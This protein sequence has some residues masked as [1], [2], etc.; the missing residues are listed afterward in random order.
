MDFAVKKFGRQHFI[1]DVPLWEGHPRHT[2]NAR[3]NGSTAIVDETPR[4]QSRAHFFKD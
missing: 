3:L 4:L 2:G 1:K